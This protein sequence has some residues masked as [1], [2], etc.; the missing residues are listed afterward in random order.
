M[1]VHKKVIKYLGE[2]DIDSNILVDVYIS[3]KEV[4]CKHSRVTTS[5]EDNMSDA[6]IV[7]LNYSTR[8]P[9]SPNPL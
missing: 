4:L 1:R 3:D 7:N 2:I 8:E 9:S 6:T 5:I